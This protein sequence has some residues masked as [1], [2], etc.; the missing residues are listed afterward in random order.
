MN[1]DIKL[2][3]SNI[4]SEISEISKESKNLSHE[5]NSIKENIKMNNFLTIEN[6]LKKVKEYCEQFFINNFMYNRRVYSFK[7]NFEGIIYKED[8]KSI[9][10]II[11]NYEGW[12]FVEEYKDS[13]NRPIYS[14]LRNDL[15]TSYILYNNVLT[16]QEVNDIIKNIDDIYNN[17]YQYFLDYLLDIKASVNH[18]FNLIKEHVDFLKS[19]ESV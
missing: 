13:N 6:K 18:S 17:L 14:I 10:L 1:D 3:F 12:A 16:K 11:N 7:E 2:N 4:L 15:S 9:K 8:N 5:I 19:E